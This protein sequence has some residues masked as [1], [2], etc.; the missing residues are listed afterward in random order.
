MLDGNQNRTMYESRKNGINIHLFETFK[1]GKHM[2]RGQVELI[3]DSYIDYQED[4]KGN[5]RKVWI[6]VNYII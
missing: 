1:P 5:N 4:V 3:D 2:Y 6:F